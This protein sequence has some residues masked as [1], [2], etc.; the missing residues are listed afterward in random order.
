[1]DGCSLRHL[2]DLLPPHQCRLL[3]H[4]SDPR[5]RFRLPRRRL[6]APCPRQHGDCNDFDRCGGSVD[7][8]LGHVWVV[9]ILR[10]LARF[11]G[12]PIPATWY[13]EQCHCSLLSDA[14]V[15]SQLATSP[16]SSRVLPRRRRR[17]RG[18]STA[19]E[20]LDGDILQGPQRRFLVA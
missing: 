5:P 3:Y 16:V 15:M 19:L 17:G 7:V 10:H 4:L 6:L 1:M 18:H 20:Q 11:S 2:P 12:L 9:D 13:V 8:R 14:N